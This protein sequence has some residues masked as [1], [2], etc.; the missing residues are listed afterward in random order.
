MVSPTPAPGSVLR[1]QLTVTD[2]LGVVSAPSMVSVTV[3][4]TP[5]AVLVGPS[6]VEAG[7]SIPLSAAHST[8]AGQIASYHWQLVPE[9]PE[10]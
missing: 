1:F 5:V 6:T 8:P 10:P 2:N 3:Q 9:T 7:Q 4:Q